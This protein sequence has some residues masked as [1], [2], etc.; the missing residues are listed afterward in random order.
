MPVSRNGKNTI[1]ARLGKIERRLA[2]IAAKLER[3]RLTELSEFASNDRRYI[4]KAFI[5]GAARG[6]GTAVGFTILGA[7]VMYFLRLIAESRL[8]YIAEFISKIIQ[9]VES[10]NC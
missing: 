6:V 9:A 10:G 2:D 5:A 8:P 3:S 7:V 4:K 1:T